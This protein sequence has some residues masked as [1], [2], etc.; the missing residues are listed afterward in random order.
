MVYNLERQRYVAVFNDV[1]TYINA[2]YHLP[3]PYLKLYYIR[4]GIMGSYTH[5]GFAYSKYSPVLKINMYYGLDK[6]RKTMIH[7]LCHVIM[8]YRHMKK[9][10]HTKEFWTLCKEFGLTPDDYGWGKTKAME[11]VW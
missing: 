2:K 4:S 10:G 7:E 6:A 1:Y 3:K 11:G 9:V 5:T 8:Q